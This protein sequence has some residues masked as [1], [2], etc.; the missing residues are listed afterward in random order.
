[1][2][3]TAKPGNVPAV[4]LIVYLLNGPYPPESLRPDVK[5]HEMGSS[6]DKVPSQQQVVM[7]RNRQLPHG[8]ADSFSGEL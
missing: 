3:L 6:E 7:V 2:S 1:M 4:R 5:S 8:L